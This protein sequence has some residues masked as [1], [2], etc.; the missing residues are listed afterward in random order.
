MT[1]KLSDVFSKNRTEEFPDDVYN[2][3]VIPLNNDEID[4]S[5]A[6]KAC[7]II[8]GRGSGKTMYLKYY[9][10]S[11][12]L[13]PQG[14]RIPIQ[15]IKNLGLYWRPDTS[16]TQHI[17]E[18][19][20]GKYWSVAFNS[21]MS[22][23]LL[24]EF[25]KLIINLANSHSIK[26]SCKEKIL[27]FKCSQQIISAITFDKK[28]INFSEA[29]NLIRSALFTLCNWINAPI[30]ETPPIVLDFKST[31]SLITDEIIGID[32][33][34]SKLSFHIF[35]DEFE[36]LIV[37]QQKIINTLIKHGRSPVLFS[38]AHKKSAVISRDTLSDEKIVERNDFKLI[39]LEGHYNK[40][41]DVFAGEVLLLRLYSYFKDSH[42]EE[43]MKEKGFDRFRKQDSYIKNIKDLANTILPNFSYKE[44]S[45]QI[46]TDDVLYRKLFNLIEEG[47]SM[48]SS[49]KKIKPES[50]IDPG[51]PE[52]TLVSSVLLNRSRNSP[53]EILNELELYKSGLNSKFKSWIPNNLVGVILLIYK[54]TPQRACPLYAGYNQYTYLSKGNIRH[55]L[56]LCHQTMLQSESNEL[57]KD[58]SS[59]DELIKIP[60][61]IQS[62]A[63][64]KTS[65]LEFEKIS[66]LG[67]HGLHLKKVANRLGKIFSYS[68][69]R[70]TQSEV[71][72]NHFTLDLSNEMELDEKTITLLNEAIIWSVLIEEKSTKTKSNESF[73]TK[74]YL[75]HPVLSPYFGISY[76]KKK[77]LKLNKDQ[78]N[79][80]FSG[81]DKS[82]N[83]LLKSLGEKWDLGEEQESL[84]DEKNIIG[85]QLGL[86]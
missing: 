1:Q 29:G 71:E 63:T 39:D 40:N 30:T 10:H 80:I 23:S 13:S 12:L 25:T 64:I 45:Y 6:S 78:T 19:W 51:F 61:N 83:S 35:I 43:L 47:L 14:K 24:L 57:N 60:I 84:Q 33:I 67:P 53:S 55:F 52:A 62:Q 37:P 70:R 79:V 42:Y 32:K 73:E 3:Y 59:I 16:F 58:I 48:H 26:D 86:I 18:S 36:N 85:K 8:G 21:Y 81:D 31:I 2:K 28:E 22:L 66:D 15:E 44:I 68:Q 56:E 41:F 46:I 9:C 65:R 49:L 76:R 27:N 77:K 69:S 72:I 17:S 4:I 74:D 34:L 50:F 54:K 38:I 82:F 20:L 5:N 75:L 11:T 7:V